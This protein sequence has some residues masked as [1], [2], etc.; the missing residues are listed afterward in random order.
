M[1]AYSRSEDGIRVHLQRSIYSH[2][3]NVEVFQTRLYYRTILQPDQL[4]EE[5]DAVQ[6]S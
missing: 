3:N 1:Q 4:A 2:A 5:E 6:F